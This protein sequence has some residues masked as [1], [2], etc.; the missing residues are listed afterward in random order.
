MS[1]TTIANLWAPPVWLRGIDEGMDKFPAFWNSN[2]V[3]TTDDAQSI[4]SG[5]GTSATMNYFPDFSETD[6]EI[7]V[8]DTAPGVNGLTSLSGAVPILNRVLSFGA[9]ALSAQVSGEDPLRKITDVIAQARLKNRDKTTIAV[10]RGIFGAGATAIGSNTG[11]LKSMRVDLATEAGS[12]ATAANL[13]SVDAFIDAKA[14]LGELQQQLI[15]GAMFV[16]STVLAALEKADVTAFKEVS[17]GPYT[18]RTYRDVPIILSDRLVRNGT[19]SGKVFETYL[20]T[21]GRFATGAKPQA[22][23]SL[24]VASLQF[25]IDR[26][27]N[28][29]TIW[30]R[31]RFVL[32]PQGIKWTGNPAGQSATNAELQTVGNWSL[33]MSS[34]QR[35]GAVCIRTNG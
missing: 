11:V 29:G 13:M 31:T 32:A 10:L 2:C 15:F 14:L 24:D 20:V 7:Q 16:H 26:A 25:F 4:A 30:D 17:K 33:A 8:E 35:F 23:D 19:T 1:L 3:V 28:N 22:G 21:P 9:T 12:G 6:D 27:K 18:L 34:A 5:P